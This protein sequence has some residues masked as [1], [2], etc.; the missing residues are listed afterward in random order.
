MRTGSCRLVGGLLWATERTSARY[1]IIVREI[2]IR[3]A[4]VV[5]G[6]LSL[7]AGF[8]VGL[9]L[10]WVSVGGLSRLLPRGLGK[11]VLPF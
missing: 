9:P 2:F 5:S 11:E 6:R 10:D 8:A 1:S 7:C 3:N 4:S